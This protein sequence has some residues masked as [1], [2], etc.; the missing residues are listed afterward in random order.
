MEHFRFNSKAYRTLIKLKETIFHPLEICF[1][2][3]CFIHS[4]KR[5]MQLPDIVI[6]KEIFFSLRLLPMDNSERVIASVKA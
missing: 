3:L 6:L 1:V 4:R 5:L 2:E